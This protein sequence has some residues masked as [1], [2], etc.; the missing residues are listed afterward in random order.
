[1][2]RLHANARVTAL[3]SLPAFSDLSVISGRVALEVARAEVGKEL[4]HAY[5]R[6]VN[7]PRCERVW[8]TLNEQRIRQ[9]CPS[10]AVLEGAFR[11]RAKCRPISAATKFGPSVYPKY[12][13]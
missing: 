4:A 10:C 11:T 3:L 9:R 8:R 12:F 1:M 13:R 7:P 5:H 2:T 6:R